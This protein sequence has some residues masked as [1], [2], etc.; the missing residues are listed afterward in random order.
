MDTQFSSGDFQYI[1]ILDQNNNLLNILDIGLSNS[2][3]WTH[4]SFDLLNYSGWPPIKVHIGTY[5][6]GY[7]GI[8]SMYVND[9]TLEVCK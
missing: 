5:N 8:S 4:K 3:T 6:N 1:L 2:Q 9:V 7:G